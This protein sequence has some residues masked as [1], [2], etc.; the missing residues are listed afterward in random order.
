M[1]TELRPPVPDDL[2]AIA[3]L[4][5]AREQAD[6]LDPSHWRRLVLDQW[7]LPLFDPASDAILAVVDSGAVTGL[8]ARFEPGG[9]AAVDPGSDGDGTSE[10]LL[11]WLEERTRR[12]GSRESRQIVAHA[13]GAAHALLAARGYRPVRSYHRLGIELPAP[14]ADPP[15]PPSGIRLR[16]VV[17]P[18]D[19]RALHAFDDQAF[20]G[21]PDYLPETF[22]SFRDVHL[23]RDR[24]LPELSLLAERAGTPAGLALCQV[25]PGETLMVDLLAVAREERRLGLGR[26]LLVTAWRG[27]ADAGYRRAV[28]EVASD[29]PGAFALY[30]RAGMAEVHRTDVLAKRI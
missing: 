11:D 21:N 25:W 19:A 6:R 10:L 3:A 26:A 12:A 18:D 9:F 27:A 1:A 5:A 23:A 17:L 4:L 20:A 8:A 22:E 2:A 24:V 30:R 16:P 13:D 28:L 14:A 29:N 7:R 15:P